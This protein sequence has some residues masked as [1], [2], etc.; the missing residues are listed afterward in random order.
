MTKVPP[1]NI[2][3]G[4]KYYENTPKNGKFP[5]NPIGIC[6]RYFQMIIVYFPNVVSSKI[7]FPFMV[8]HHIKKLLLLEE[9][10]EKSESE[11][12]YDA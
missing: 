12:G 9:I 8:L 6:Y 4:S 7:F 3:W 2:F 1:Y 10:L 11:V 5:Q